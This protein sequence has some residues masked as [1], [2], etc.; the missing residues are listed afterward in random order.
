MRMTKEKITMHSVAKFRALLILAVIPILSASDKGM[1]AQLEGYY[2][3]LA[4]LCTEKEGTSLLPC[5]KK[6]EDCMIIKGVDRNHAH[7]EIWTVQKN[8]A[9]CQID[10]IAVL[11]GHTLIYSNDDPLINP[12]GARVEVALVN[13][14]LKVGYAG[15]QGLA[16]PP[17]CG[18]SARLDYVKFSL[19]ERRP[20]EN[21]SCTD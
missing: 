9:M 3:H 12:S 14:Q 5:P 8:G 11:N 21:H 1:M 17:F 13:G 7:L 15:H 16:A 20:V 2:S 19:T 4:P 6:V 18:A 10:G